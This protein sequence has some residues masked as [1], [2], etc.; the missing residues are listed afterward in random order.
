MRFWRV[1]EM[2]QL[3]SGKPAPQFGD[4]SSLSVRIRAGSRF[5]RFL[6]FVL[7]DVKCLRVTWGY[8]Y[9]RLKT[10]ATDGLDVTK[11]GKISASVRNRIL[12][13]ES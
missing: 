5:K 1:N 9:P 2:I 11:K 4:E 12:I 3:V 10:T 13:G 7:I 8:T 6:C